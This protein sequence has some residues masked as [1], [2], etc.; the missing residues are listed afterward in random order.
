[1]RQ[2]KNTKKITERNNISVNNYLKEVN[3]YPMATVDEEVTLAQ[4]IRQGGKEADKARQRLIEANLRF[5]ISVANQ[6]HQPNMDLSD[7]ISEGNIGLIKAA[8]L[9][10]DTRGFKFISYAVWWIRQSISSAIC[11]NG[12]AIRLPLNQQALLSK[13]FILMNKTIQKE[14][15]EPTTAEFAEFA[16]ISEYKAS[17]LIE[18]NH[19]TLSMDAPLS[20]DTETS[21]GDLVPSRYR[22]DDSL[23]KESLHQDIAAILNHILTAKEREIILRSF[24]I[25]CKEEGLE[26]IGFSL[27]LSRERVRQIREKALCKIRRSNKVGILAQ[28]IR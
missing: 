22:T 2:F 24:G 16:D 12:R 4:R 15:R 9:F 21:V 27:G 25:G 7:L 26:E 28:Y 10:D 6:Y 13:Y 3:R 5:V 23:D 14:Q 1:M 18:Q 17:M 11:E 8:E 19:K 20:E